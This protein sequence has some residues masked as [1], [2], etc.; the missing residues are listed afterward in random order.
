MP[1]ASRTGGLMGA[2]TTS[3][4]IRMT[5]VIASLLGFAT[6]SGAYIDASPTLGRLVKE[7]TNIVV[8]RVGKVSKDRRAILYTKAA[9]LKG[10]YPADQF[11]HRLTAGWHPGESKLILDWAEPG[12]VAFCFLNGKSAVTCIDNYWYGAAAAEAPL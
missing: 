10:K 4:M 3:A 2:I 8:L 7:S 11:K 5:C 9:D 12:R 1:E 6:P